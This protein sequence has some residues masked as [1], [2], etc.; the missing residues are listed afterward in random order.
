MYSEIINNATGILLIRMVAGILFFFQGY[1]K[2]FNVKV[3]NVVRTFSQPV[4][5]IHLP[6]SF[7]RLS[8]A[9]SSYIEFIGGLLLFIGL[10]K[11]VTL[12]FLAGN[13]ILVALIFSILKPMWDMQFYFPRLLLIFILLF[14][15]TSLDLFSLDYFLSTWMK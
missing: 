14:I 15:S 13:L 3:E 10:F 2:I 6:N 4:A 11:N 9:I 5:K 7:L 1:D 12:Y 8:V